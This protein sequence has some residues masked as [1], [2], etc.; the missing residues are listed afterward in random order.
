M[1]IED[2]RPASRPGAAWIA[3]AVLALATVAAPLWG[4]PEHSR[5]TQRACASCHSNPAGGA[6]L[7]DAGK[8]FKGKKKIPAAA[9]ARHADYVGSARCRSCHLGEHQAWSDTRHGHAL[10]H[11]AAA[12]SAAVAAMAGRLGVTLKAPPTQTE[13]CVVCHVTGFR[14]TG[15]FPAAD[16]AANAALAVVGCESCHGPGSLHV[17]APFSQKKNVIQ[18]AVPASLCAQCHTA[19]TSPEFD[20][21]A[22]VMKGAHPKR[23]D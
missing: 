12:D 18:R 2:R 21:A 13:A 7:T 16:S 5:Q 9:V 19:K 8:A 10:E 22:M 4:F 1:G 14:L 11:L 23:E 3:G 6:E 17:S 20:Y 15:G